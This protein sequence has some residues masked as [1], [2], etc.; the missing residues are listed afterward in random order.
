MVTWADRVAALAGFGLFVAG[1]A[2]VY[3]PAALMVAGGM[4]LGAALWRVKG[5]A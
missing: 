1:V 5:W 2:M 3:V 4:L